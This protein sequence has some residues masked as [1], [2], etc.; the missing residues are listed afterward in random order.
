MYVFVAKTQGATIVSTLLYLAPPTT[1]L[2]VL[3]MFGD[4]V[5]PLR[6]TGLLVGAAGVLLVLRRRHVLQRDL[7]ERQPAV[8]D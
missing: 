1:M 6:C 8:S 7:A 4:P 3:L 5:T 2:G